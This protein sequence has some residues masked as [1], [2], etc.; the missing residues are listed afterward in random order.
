MCRMNNKQLLCITFYDVLVFAVMILCSVFFYL[1]P[2]CCLYIDPLKHRNLCVITVCINKFLLSLQVPQTAQMVN[3]QHSRARPQ[4]KWHHL[5]TNQRAM[6]WWKNRPMVSGYTGCILAI[7]RIQLTVLYLDP[8]PTNYYIVVF[9]F[10]LLVLPYQL[11]R[12]KHCRRLWGS[13]SLPLKH[14]WRHAE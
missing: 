6:V 13:N 4:L 8:K 11:P 3:R 1:W 12:Q 5:T 7:I 2:Y 10:I 14:W 9:A